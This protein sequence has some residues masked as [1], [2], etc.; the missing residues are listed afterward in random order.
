[1]KGRETGRQQMVLTENLGKV[2][3]HLV[4]SGLIGRINAERLGNDCWI[5][6]GRQ[7]GC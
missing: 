6:E 5:A 2:K 4:K 3:E 7:A 1:M